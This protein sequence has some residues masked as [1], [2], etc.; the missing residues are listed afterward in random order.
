MALQTFVKINHVTNL[1]DA[2]YCSGMMV[3]QLGFALNPEDPNYTSPSRFK[4]ISGWVSGVEFVGEFSGQTDLEILDLIKEYPEINWIESDRL[5]T[6]EALAEQGFSLIYKTRLKEIIHLE[7]QVSILISKLGLILH[8][9]PET[10]SLT[11]SE[12]ESIT[13]LSSKCKVVLGGGLDA[14]NALEFINDL[15]LYGISLNGGQEI[16][17][18]LREFDL[19]AEVLEKLEIED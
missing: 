11:A 15:N 12:I 6:L 10:D 7:P 1:T 4:E 2:R 16:K 14:D 17:T 9:L 19:M 13:S 18:G 3:N 5:E 8:I